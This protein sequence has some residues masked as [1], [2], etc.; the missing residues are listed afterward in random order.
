MSK[1]FAKIVTKQARIINISSL[2]GINIWKDRI[3]YNVSKSALI[4][5]TKVLARALAPQISVN[6]VCPGY[7]DLSEHKSKNE[8]KE[9]MSLQKIPM[10]RYG[11]VEDVFE[12][13]YFFSSCSQF[14]TGQVLIVD[15]GQS[16][17]H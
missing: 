4:Q 7:I 14:I 10:N 6:V 2:G 15:G 1:E 3:D 9:K 11:T 12:A 5:L 17:I 8:N 16:L 13:V